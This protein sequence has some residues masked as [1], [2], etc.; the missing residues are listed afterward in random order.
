MLKHGSFAD[1]PRACYQYRL[2]KGAPAHK[3]FQVPCGG[4]SFT[5][6]SIT[7]TRQPSMKK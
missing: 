3:F 5:M 7:L 6:P 4:K 2:E 1:L